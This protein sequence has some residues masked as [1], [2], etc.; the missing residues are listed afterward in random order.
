MPTPVIGIT[1][2]AEPE[3]VTLKRGYIEFVR[4]AGG[5]PILL[6]PL[7]PDE[8]EKM[9][10]RIDGL[11]ISGGDDPKMEVFGKTTHPAARLMQPDRQ[12]SEIAWL[13]SLR[14]RRDFPVLGVC[15]GMQLM[16]L[17]AGG[18]LDQH[19]PDHLATA[20]DHSGNRA[21]RIVGEWGERMV[22]SNHRQAV[23]SPG[24][25][26]VRA[27][28]TD[29]VIEAIC[30][31]GRKFYYG[32]QWHPERTDDASVGFGLFEKLVDSARR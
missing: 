32:V 9:L 3:R 12:A 28:A 29:G 20:S 30:D 5:I 26:D 15:L 22:C 8:I 27:T 14:E 1:V 2:D 7:A 18:D 24:H 13:D 16:A 6:A 23:R 19:L 31:P 4:R 25:L 10:S 17:H 11:V 21:H